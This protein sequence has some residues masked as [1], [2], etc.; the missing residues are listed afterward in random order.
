MR[1][2]LNTPI[3]TSFGT[4]DFLPL[5]REQAK[6]WLH[7]GEFTSAVGHKP[8]AE[9]MTELFGVTVPFNR[10]SITMRAGDEALVFSLRVRLPEGKVLSKQEIDGETDFK[11][12]VLILWH[13]RYDIT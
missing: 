12:G 8:T 7:R 10:V 3:L 13:D 9:I 2:I 1:Y 11:L 4:Y 5:T 6:A